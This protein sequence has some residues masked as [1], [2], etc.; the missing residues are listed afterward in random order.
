M[1]TFVYPALAQ[2][3]DF[4]RSNYTGKNILSY[5]TP[6]HTW[7]KSNLDIKHDMREKGMGVDI[8]GFEMIRSKYYWWVNV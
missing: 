1:Y 5:D 3:R 4:S 8:R 6:L 7:R 2:T